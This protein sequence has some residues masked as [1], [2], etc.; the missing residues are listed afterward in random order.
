MLEFYL[1]FRSNPIQKI[2][3]LIKLH[4][5]GVWQSAH[6]FIRQLAIAPVYW[7]AFIG[8]H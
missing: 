8:E 7:L 2:S 5:L 6:E 3:E 4:I 1:W